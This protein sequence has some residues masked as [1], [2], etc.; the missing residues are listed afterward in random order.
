L[1]G[2]DP[3][4]SPPVAGTQL[5]PGGILRHPGCSGSNCAPTETGF[6]ASEHGH[7]YAPN[8]VDKW[9][10]TRNTT[11]ADIYWTVSS[12]NPMQTVLTRT[13]LNP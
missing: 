10:T 5:A 3:N 8:I 1:R 2:G 11:A 6:D 12:W 9:T 4:I 13:R 7:L